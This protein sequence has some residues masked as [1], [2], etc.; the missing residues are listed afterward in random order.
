MYSL[1]ANSMQY[2]LVKCCPCILC[3]VSD[4][5][6]RK[7]LENLVGFFF[8]YWQRSIPTIQTHVFFLGRIPPKKDIQQGFQRILY[9]KVY[10]AARKQTGKFSRTITQVQSLTQSLYFKNTVGSSN[11]LKHNY[12]KRGDS[13]TI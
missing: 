2:I 5:T 1:K 11:L 13:E 9:N 6:P 4:G 3:I 7:W 12:L 8:F 10:M